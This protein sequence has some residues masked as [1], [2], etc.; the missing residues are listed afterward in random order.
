MQ[1]ATAITD[2]MLGAAAL[3]LVADRARCDHGSGDASSQAPAT[4]GRRARL[5]R[6][7]VGHERRR[8][9]RDTA[10]TVIDP[11]V[12]VLED[13]PE[14]RSLLTRGLREEGFEVTTAGTASEML[15][16]RT[17][18]E[19]DAMIVDVGLPDADGRDLVQALRARGRRP[20]IFLTA[21]DAL[22]TASQA[23]RPAGTTI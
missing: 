13:D 16:L 20:V 8:R 7:D 17:D 1:A 5:I 6:R 21:R 22:P 10:E 18:E 19:P 11:H 3:V 14:L 2:L 15:D 12:I 23:S 4:P 9:G